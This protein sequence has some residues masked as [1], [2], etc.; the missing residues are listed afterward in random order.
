MSSKKGKNKKGGDQGAA[1][2]KDP[3]SLGKNLTGIEAAPVQGPKVVEG[4]QAGGASPPGV[5]GETSFAA[6]HFGLL[7]RYADELQ[8]IGTMPP[9]SSVGG[10][11]RA[12]VGAVTGQSL[13]VLLDKIGERLAFERTGTRL[14]EAL[15]VKHQLVG[16]WSGGPSYDDLKQIRD[17]EHRHFELLSEAM[18][19]LGGDPTALTPS[20]DL[21]AVESLGLQ[22]VIADVRT[23]LDQGMHAILV[24]ELADTAGWDMLCDLAD[25]AGQD[26]LVRQ[27]RQAERLEGEHVAKVQRWLRNKLGAPAE[28]Q[29]EAPP[30]DVTPPPA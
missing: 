21:A 14:Y 1:E 3:T 12:A 30:L 19:D 26:D 7:Q 5:A 6:V 25:A 16:S 22:K 20:A 9:P 27:F 11:A 15:M 13:L 17:E 29:F 4:A 10:A 28:S 8:P 18:E 23:T 2:V 24:A